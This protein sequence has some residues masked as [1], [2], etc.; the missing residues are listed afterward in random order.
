MEAR[1]LFHTAAPAFHDRNGTDT[2]LKAAALLPRTLDLRL[3]IR[4]PRPARF[5]YVNVPIPVTWLPPVHRYDEV[6]PDEADVMLLPRRYGGLSLPV[7]EAAARGLPVLMTDLEPQRAWFPEMALLPATVAEP[8]IAMRGGAF[9]V[10]GADPRELADRIVGL[11]EDDAAVA[12]LS[13]VARTF[14]QSLS[15]DAWE[16]PYDWNLN[17]LP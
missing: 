16:G 12:Y 11:R 6:I 10:Y 2:V 14:G 9:D 5:R 1:V 17:A 13:D 15:W 3:L 7:Q 4:G 8:L